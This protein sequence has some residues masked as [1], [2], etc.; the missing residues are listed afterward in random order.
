MGTGINDAFNT[1]KFNDN[2]IKNI[3]LKLIKKYKC[4]FFFIWNKDKYLLVQF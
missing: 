3:I 1:I 2:I 4:R